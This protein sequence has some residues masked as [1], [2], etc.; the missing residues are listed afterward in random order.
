MWHDRRRWQVQAAGAWLA[1]AM[2]GVSSEL[3]VPE[4]LARYLT[5]QQT[6]LCSGIELDGYLF[7]NDSAAGETLQEY[8]VVEFDTGRQVDA[9]VYTGMNWI[10]AWE[11]TLDILDGNSREEIDRIDLRRVQSLAQHASCKHCY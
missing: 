7:L 4:L 1:L 11:K 6:P 8:A 9:I 3:T 5:S 10:E 2:P